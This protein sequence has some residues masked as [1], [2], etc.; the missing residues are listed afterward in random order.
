MSLFIVMFEFSYTNSKRLSLA[1]CLQ[2]VGFQ[3]RTCAHQ[4]DEPS[5]E[6]NNKQRF[7]FR[8]VGVFNFFAAQRVGAKQKSRGINFY[9]TSTPKL[10]SL[11]VHFMLV[12]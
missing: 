12:F 2:L 6:H 3:C 9:K 5:G 4:H 10:S 7:V 8:V 1:A 11:G